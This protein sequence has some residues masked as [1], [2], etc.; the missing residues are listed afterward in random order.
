MLR[1][2]QIKQSRL[3]R[4]F[5]QLMHEWLS[6]GR[7]SLLLRSDLGSYYAFCGDTFCFYEIEDGADF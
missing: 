1:Q 2:E 6:P 3:L 4:F 7:P 5:S